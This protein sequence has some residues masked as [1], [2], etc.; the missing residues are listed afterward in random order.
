MASSFELNSIALQSAEQMG[1]RM[2][3][4]ELS[5]EQ[6][7]DAVLEEVCAFNGEVNAIVTLD[8][9]GARE[10]ARRADEARAVG[11]SLGPMHGIPVTIK[12]AYETA[13]RQ[14]LG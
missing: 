5:A 8:E 14:A 6:I 2:T 9:A 11:E 12:D 1:Q 10:Q 4:G 7:L 13:C 3:S